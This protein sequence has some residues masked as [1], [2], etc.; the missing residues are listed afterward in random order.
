MEPAARCL[1]RLVEPVHLV[2]Y[3]SGEPTD[4]LMA[5][6][7]RNFWDGYF[8]GRAAP[9]GRVIL[10]DLADAPAVARDVLAHVPG[11]ARRC[12][13]GGDPEEDLA[14]AREDLAQPVELPAGLGARDVE[15]DLRPVATGQLH[16]VRDRGCPVAERGLAGDGDDHRPSGR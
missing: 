2:T 10:G 15:H 6:G 14:G 13:L 1:Y 8:A 11:D 4:A 12:R 5:L 7:H 3:F 16:R 9:L